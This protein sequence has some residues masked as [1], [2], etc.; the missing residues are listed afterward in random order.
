MPS[1]HPAGINNEA[2]NKKVRHVENWVQARL[3]CARWKRVLVANVGSWK[4][5]CH[6]HDVENVDLRFT[7]S[8]HN[9]V[10]WLCLI[11]G[12]IVGG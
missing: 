1:H 11:Y 7:F 8:I 9:L 3:I 10:K 12:V 2:E 5:L 6:L 4:W